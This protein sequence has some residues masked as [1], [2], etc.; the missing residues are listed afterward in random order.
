M[1]GAV[2]CTRPRRV[3]AARSGSDS[4]AGGGS[5]RRSTRCSYRF[6]RAPV[7][8]VDPKRPLLR[9]LSRELRWRPLARRRLV[10]ELAA[11][12][13]DS[14]ADLRSAGWPADN[15]EAEAARRLG[16]PETVAAAFQAART[17]PWSRARG[18][19]SPAWIAA[20]AMTLVTAWAAEVPQASGAKT[21]ASAAHARR[22]AADSRPELGRPAATPM[23]HR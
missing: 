17:G 16:D 9:A 15:A 20:G 2:G 6:R 22:A 21:T 3:A 5:A 4:R 10:S 23:R 19:R 18:L 12:L 11:H 1:A 8:S 13:E 7:T 14:A